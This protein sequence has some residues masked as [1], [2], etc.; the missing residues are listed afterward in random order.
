LQAGMNKIHGPRKLDGK[1]KIQAK[2]LVQVR[3]PVLYV[4]D[5][6]QGWYLRRLRPRKNKKALLERNF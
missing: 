5:Q 6:Y 2:S 1:T 4:L 3:L